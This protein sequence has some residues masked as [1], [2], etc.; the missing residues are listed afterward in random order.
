MIYIRCYEA[1]Q[2][3]VKSISFDLMAMRLMAAVSRRNNK[4][5]KEALKTLAIDFHDV[6]TGLQ[7]IQCNLEQSH[8]GNEHRSI[9]RSR[10]KTFRSMSVRCN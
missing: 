6:N 4:S 5:M 1:E 10:H 2:L 7:T 3:K 9:V 8:Q